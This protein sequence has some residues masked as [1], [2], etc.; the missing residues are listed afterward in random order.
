MGACLRLTCTARSSR[1]AANA[2][3]DGIGA[4]LATASEPVHLACQQLPAVCAPALQTSHSLV[5]QL[6]R[7]NGQHKV[8]QSVTC[9]RDATL[10]PHC[11]CV[12]LGVS[13][14]VNTH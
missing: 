12:Q 3:C 14:S 5:T 2:P 1:Y 9:S 11:W 6:V 7:P 13:I 4:D 10:C 8:G